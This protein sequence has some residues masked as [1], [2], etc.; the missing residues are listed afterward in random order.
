MQKTAS[1]QDSAPTPEST[2]RPRLTAG[3]LFWRL[4]ALIPFASI[5]FIMLL[6]AW[7]Q[8]CWAF[9]KHGGIV[10]INDPRLADLAPAPAKD[11]VP[12][13]SIQPRPNQD[14]R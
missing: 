3:I 12:T 2:A 14:P 6:R 11:V 5:G 9:L 4:L 10:M 8:Q 7:V 13:H 1:K